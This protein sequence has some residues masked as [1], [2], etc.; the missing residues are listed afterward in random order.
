MLLFEARYFGRN[1][2]AF[3]IL[4]SAARTDRSAGDIG[5]PSSRNFWRA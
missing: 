4:P 1:G 2:P 5:Q 3:S